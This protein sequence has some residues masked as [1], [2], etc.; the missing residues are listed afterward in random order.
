MIIYSSAPDIHISNASC[1]VLPFTR[2]LIYT[3]KGKGK[4]KQCIKKIAMSVLVLAMVIT[5]LPM[6]T[7]AATVK[8]NKKA[9]TLY[10]GDKVTLKLN[11]AKSVSWSSSPTVPPRSGQS[12]HSRF[13]ERSFPTWPLRSIP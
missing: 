1:S 6:N 3:K 13:S 2:R 4:M 9:A 5:M 12:R 11:G 8:L 10:V 7:Q